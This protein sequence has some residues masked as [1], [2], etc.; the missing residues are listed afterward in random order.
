MII[1]EVAKLTGLTAKAI[2]H[3]EK[4][5]LINVGRNKINSYQNYSEQDVELLKKIK[6]FR[7]MEFSIEEIKQIFI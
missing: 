5:G 2:R 7:Y 4:E 6:L 1:K 3:Y